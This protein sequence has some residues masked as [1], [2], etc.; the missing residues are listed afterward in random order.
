MSATFFRIFTAKY[1]SVT[2]STRILF[3]ILLCT[4]L[5]SCGKEKHAPIDFE[6]KQLEVSSE[7]ILPD[8]IA[9]YSVLMEYFVPTSGS[10]VLRKNISDKTDELLVSFFTEEKN[11]PLDSLKPMVERH[12]KFFLE[13]LNGE[14]EYIRMFQTTVYPDSVYQIDKVVSLRYNYYF[15]DGGAHGIDGVACLNFLKDSGEVLTIERLT[16][17]EAGLLN[18]VKES[19]VELVEKQTG[20]RFEDTYFFNYDKFF[21]SK[22]FAFAAD[23]L[24]FYY[25]PYE[26]APYAVG[27]IDV[28]VPYEKIREYANFVE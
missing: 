19:F 23:G 27:V 22:E 18:A 2:M 5:A 16:K 28:L 24:H 12:M 21:L 7:L 1:E 15:Y 6:R 11:V 4:L 25:Q 3:G 14:E 8:S 20:E 9:S 13:G 26:L 17:D 10:D